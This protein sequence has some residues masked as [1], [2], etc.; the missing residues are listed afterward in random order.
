MGTGGY[1]RPHTFYPLEYPYFSSVI[2]LVK[3]LFP[4]VSL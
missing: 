1:H 4:A 3:V 2:R